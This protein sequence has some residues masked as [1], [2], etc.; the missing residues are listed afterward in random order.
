MILC[1]WNETLYLIR[2][3]FLF[4]MSNTRTYSD[5]MSLG[6]VALRNFLSIRG[7]PSSGYGKVEL[8]ARA[9]SASEMNLPIVM[10]SEEQSF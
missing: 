5:F 9:F 2:L 1:K 3:N 7:I 4:R 6:T 8:V 10:S